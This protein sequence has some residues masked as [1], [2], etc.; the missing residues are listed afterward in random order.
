[1]EEEPQT[2]AV[3]KEETKLGII[4]TIISTPSTFCFSADASCWERQCHVHRL[5]TLP[6]QASNTSLLKDEEPLWLCS[7]YHLPGTISPCFRLLKWSL[8]CLRHS[9]LRHASS[10]QYFRIH[11]GVGWR[12]G[13]WG[14][15]A[16]ALEH[17]PRLVSFWPLPGHP[18]AIRDSCTH[19]LLTLVCFFS[20]WVE[21][22]SIQYLTV[23]C[24][25]WQLW[26]RDIE[27][28]GVLWWDW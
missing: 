25:P 4:C 22:C 24:F 14:L 28:F 6:T 13:W 26:H 11:D 23:L 5:L 8:F 21:H 12:G 1:M 17:A 20:M 27:V 19:L 15:S 9:V 3:S 16:A 2:G 18:L 10:F 7:V